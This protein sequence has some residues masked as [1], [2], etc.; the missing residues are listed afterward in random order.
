MK[1]LIFITS[2][3]PYEQGEAFIETE[4]PYL[5]SAFDR[6]I[7]ITRNVRGEK[8]RPIP[9]DVKVYRYDPASSFADY[10]LIPALFLKNLNKI[11][12]LVKEEISFRNESGQPIS[13][14]Q[15]LFLLKAIIKGIQFRDFI[16]EVIRKEKPEGKIL[17]Y[18]YWLNI[19]ARAICLLEN[20]TGARIARAHRIDLYEEE[21]DQKYIPLIK[22][23]SLTLD[24]VFFI[25]EH[26]KDYFERK[27]GASASE[28]VIARLGINNPFPFNPEKSSP[29][30][31]RI[32]SCS[33]LIKVKRVHLIINALSK[34]KTD[35]KLFWNHFGDG[36]L[37]NELHDL[38][39]EKLNDKG[40]IEFRF[41]GQVPNPELMEFYNSNDVNLFINT[42]SSEGIPVSI[43]EAQ[44]FGIPVIATDTGGT[45][46]IVR[47]NTGTL[48]PCQFNPEDLTSLIEY[49]V[50]LSN[51]RRTELKRTIYENW[52]RYFNASNNYE[53]FI[54][55]VN[56]ILAHKIND[57]I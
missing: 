26:G 37:K 50:A 32:V 10:M 51:D 2:R 34:V 38:A 33:S 52:N 30:V 16:K 35:R 20:F 23:V 3:F 47:E 29:D 14:T 13:I 27:S 36:D 1:T 49:Y 39:V 19:G 17:L 12:P 4:F 31:F 9:A 42:S 57:P 24:A 22:K 11:L 40:T 41:M 48:L 28:K 21:T 56:R 6:V 44:S 5:Y 43:M 54:R 7:I 18:S 25:S 53:E 45:K 55:K 8:R 46:E 15:K